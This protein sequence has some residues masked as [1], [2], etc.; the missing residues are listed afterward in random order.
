MSDER[1]WVPRG[2]ELSPKRAA[3]EIVDAA[4]RSPEG[5]RLQRLLAKVAAVR[6]PRMAD[7]GES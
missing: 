6:D 1:P 4:W 3:R 2:P 5:L 7:E